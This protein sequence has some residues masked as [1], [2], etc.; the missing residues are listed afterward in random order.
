V[1]VPAQRVTSCF[2]GGEKRD[3]LFITSARGDLPEAALAKQPYAG[4]VF[5]CQ[6]DTQGQKVN[7]FG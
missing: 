3:Q 5:I 4:D 6:T 2:F 7:F 1:K